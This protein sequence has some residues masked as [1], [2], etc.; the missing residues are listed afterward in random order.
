M[1]A[2]APPVEPEDKQKDPFAV[3]AEIGESFPKGDGDEFADLCRRAKPDHVAEINRMFAEGEP[4]F[5]MIDALEEGGSWPKLKALLGAASA[6]EILVAILSP[7]AAQAEALKA[8]ATWVNEARDFTQR[9]AE[10]RHP[11]SACLPASVGAGGG[12]VV[13]GGCGATAMSSRPPSRTARRAVPCPPDRLPM[14]GASDSGQGPFSATVRKPMDR[15]RTAPPRPRPS[16]PGR[17]GPAQQTMGVWFLAHPRGQGRARRR[18]EAS[19]SG[20]DSGVI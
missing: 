18:G 12:L 17:A 2:D 11:Y 13:G 8:D 16:P 20:H 15:G 4:T 1:G 5:E 9:G 7:S 3:F 19:G 6:K 10:T 14:R